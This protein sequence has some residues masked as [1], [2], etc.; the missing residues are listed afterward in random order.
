METGLWGSVEVREEGM[1]VGKSILRVEGV[2]LEG[3]WSSP[4]GGVLTSEVQCDRGCT[5]HSKGPE[6]MNTMEPPRGFINS[7]LK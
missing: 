6:E 3:A 7:I 2:N 4:W 5:V 1:Y